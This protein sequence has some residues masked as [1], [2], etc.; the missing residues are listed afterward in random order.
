MDATTAPHDRLH[1]GCG[2]I[3]LDGWVNID[4]QGGAADLLH[5][6][7][8]PLPYPDASIRFI[9]AEHFIEHVERPAALRLLREC[10]RVLR[11]G[12]VVRLSTPDL[13]YLVGLY[14]AGKLDEW[15]D[16]G[17][18]PQSPCEMLNQGMRMWGHS[19]VF[20]REDLSRLA[21]EAGY[22]QIAFR[23]WRESP[24]PELAGLESR[25]FH[26]E[27]IAELSA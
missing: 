8:T 3:R 4:A 16:M 22:R 5:D 21:G 11:P 27:L 23:K 12:G 1:L 6:L 14:V 24:H 9:Y 25:P 26:R 19:W 10:R 20:D 7:R 18:R 17:W 13:R 2:G 15:H